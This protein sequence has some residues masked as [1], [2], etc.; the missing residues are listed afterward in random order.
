MT[1]GQWPSR[2]RGRQGILERDS[3]DGKKESTARVDSAAIM[4]M[5]TLML[6]YVIYTSKHIAIIDPIKDNGIPSGTEAI[7]TR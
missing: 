1:M 3:R 4:S 2:G 5:P 7:E 6:Y